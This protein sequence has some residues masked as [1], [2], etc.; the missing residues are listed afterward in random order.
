M[1][2]GRRAAGRGRRATS[3]SSSP[4]SGRSATPPTRCA[5]AEPAATP[6]SC[7]S[8]PGCRAA[9]QHRVFE[10]HTGPPGRAGHQRRRDLADRA[11]HPLRR[12]PRHRPDLPLQPPAPRCSGCRSS[13]SRRPSANQRAGRCGRVADGI[14][15]RLY[16]EEDFDGRPGVHRPGDPAHQPGLGHPADDRARPRR[17]RRVPVRRPARPPQRHATA[18]Q[19][20]EEL[21][22]LDP[23]RDGPAQAA[24]PARPPAGPAAGRPAARPDG[25]RGRPQRLRCARCW[26]SPPRCRSR[27]RASG[28]PD[29]Q[30]AADAAARAGSPTTDSD[31]LACLNL[32]NYLRSSRRSCPA[33]AFR[34]LCQREFLNYLRVR[35]W[36]DLESASSARSPS[37]SGSTRRRAPGRATTRRRRASTRRCSPGCSR[38]SGCAD[39]DKREYL[40][41]RGARFAIF[42]GLGAVQEAAA[43]GD[44]RRAGRDLPAVGPRSTPRSSRS[45]SSRSA[46]TWSSAAT[47]SRTGRRKRGAVMAVRAGHAVRRAARR[48]PHGA[49]TA[50]STR[51][52]R[53]EL[54][55]RHALVEGEWQHPPPVLRATTASCSTRSR[56]SSTGPAGATSSST[57]RRC[58]TSTTRGSRPTSSPA[59]TST[60]GGRRPAATEPDLLD[61][62]PRDAAQRRRPS[63][64]DR[65]R[66][67]RRVAARASCAC[68]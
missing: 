59:R 6:R 56:S 23:T 34:R 64:V 48:R 28:P 31:F 22:A 2:R 49:A 16:A 35:E 18:S 4:A 39:P 24:H 7:R 45:G 3:W 38:T 32:W 37:S 36:Q 51:S 44:G 9:E 40:G 11:R 12:R 54:F 33:S 50:G 68:R 65:G 27:T 17:R 53:R 52:C 26:S 21:G 19:L 42:P 10:P 60:A 67:P 43:L 66:L 47:A 57:T 13:R 63:G 14:C 41:A 29:K 8:T 15:I 25:P 62:R 1:R 5:S 58:S 55:I 46:R 20:L 30:Q 61:L